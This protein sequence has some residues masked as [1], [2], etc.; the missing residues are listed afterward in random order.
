[1][2]DT[3]ASQ[4]AAGE[5][6]ERPASVVKE[7]VE[8]ALDAGAK[9]V[10]VEIQR[11]GVGLIRVSDDGSGMTEEE[12]VLAF[13]RHATSKLKSVEDLAAVSQLGFRGEALPSI[14]SVA[15]VLLQTAE[16]G[17]VSGVEVRMDGGKFGGARAAGVPRGTR[18]EVT[19]LFYNVPARRKFLKAETTES[20][21]VEHQVRLHALAYPQV[22][23]TFRKDGRTVYDL[24]ATKDLRVRICGLLGQ[25]LGR[26][27]ITISE[28]ENRGIKVWGQ[29]LPGGHARR[30][31]RHQC[32][33]LNGRPIEDTAISRALRDAYRGMLQ[34]GLHPTVFLVM[35]MD[36]HGVD[37]NVHPAKREVRFHRPHEVRDAVF[38]AVD[39]CLNPKVESPV[40]PPPPKPVSRF[41]PSQGT[42][43]RGPFQAP[44]ERQE[45]LPS[46][47]VA[48]TPSESGARP[49]SPAT[50][51]KE[52]IP[53]PPVTRAKLP[54][55]SSIGVLR[56]KYQLFEGE[57]GLVVMDP[58]AARNRIWYERL[59][60]GHE[61][62]SV[63]SQGLLVPEL[64]E[65]DARDLDVALNHSQ[66]FSDAGIQVEAFGGNTLR[67][68]SLPAMLEIRDVRAFV[69]RMIDELV[70]T[71]G[72]RRGK[73]LAFE[74]FAAELAERISQDLG[75]RV[76]D[77]KA[78][79]GE[80][81]D[82]ELPYCTA[83]GRPT[84][85]QLSMNELGRR[86][87]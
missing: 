35:E 37:V 62:E 12:A 77:A 5:V 64:I 54:E 3:L 67:I 9:S 57:E 13:E 1:M 74:L 81:F 4:V 38:H 60:A 63:A 76:P 45:E 19:D 46:K 82:C 85:I 10:E 20:A 78:L 15:K 32:V 21:H 65:L 31:R 48:A 27:L 71:V 70:E 51:Q 2:P 41:D 43:F 69:T 30:G 40:A 56:G 84:L 7:L 83:G 18:I 33:F 53:A 34:D 59:M 86:F 58:V 42:T 87:G 68:G 14:A 25:E 11:G 36:P 80:L 50:E 17:A 49:G 6:V 75:W 24:P 8:N 52:E 28:F 29:V 22:R 55:W 26:E 16:P 73:T 44:V 79:L 23:F 47:P 72:T 66:H 61:E 39:R